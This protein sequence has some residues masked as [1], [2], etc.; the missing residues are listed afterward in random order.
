MTEGTDIYF[1]PGVYR[2]NTHEGQFALRHELAHVVQQT[3]NKAE[4]MLS[5]QAAEVAADEAANSVAGSGVVGQ[6]AL[7]TA[8]L[9]PG[10]APIKARVPQNL[11]NF[12]PT[13][14]AKLRRLE[15]RLQHNKLTWEDCFAGPQEIEQI[16]ASRPDRTDAAIQ[17]LFDRVEEKLQSRGLGDVTG[18]AE[19]AR[20]IRGTSTRTGGSEASRHRDR[21]SEPRGHHGLPQYLG[22][23]YE[24]ILIGLP[25]DLHYLYHEEVDRLLKL[26]R[27]AGSDF[28]ERLSPQEREAMY[29]RLIEHAKDF[30][31]RYSKGYVDKRTRIAAA[32]RRGIREAREATAAATSAKSASPVASPPKPAAGTGSTGSVS[33]AGAAVSGQT[34]LSGG[35]DEARADPAREVRASAGGGVPSPVSE[36]VVAPAEQSVVETGPAQKP[37]SL[38]GRPA[39]P[40]S[41]EDSRRE[42]RAAILIDPEPASGFGGPS[43]SRRAVVAGAAGEAASVVLPVLIDAL[44][45]YGANLAAERELAA[46]ADQI[47]AARTATTGVVVV[48]N[49][50]HTLQGDPT[51]GISTTQF[52]SLYPV[53]GFTDLSSGVKVLK[54]RPSLSASVQ[55]STVDTVYLWVPP[56]PATH[57][58]TV[59][60]APSR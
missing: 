16:F 26:P 17:V 18:I 42:P 50:R 12:T 13:Q 33:K 27:G 39:V 45:R 41:E 31:R 53:A 3:A 37:T 23:Q 54:Q 59:P 21:L 55:F 58:S 35:T 43:P 32:L 38:A 60:V 57:P 36:P 15:A 7:G 11:P 44:S 52:V 6:V 14:E 25:E 9:L 49:F 4:P 40:I 19:D 2:P 47:A 22:G 28:Y 56:L 30:D 10:D 29:R 5:A 34:G 8:Q 20:D 51:A 24:Q 1:A 46:R 48:I